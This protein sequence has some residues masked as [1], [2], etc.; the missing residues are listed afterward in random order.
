MPRLRLKTSLLNSVCI[1]GIVG[2]DGILVTAQNPEINPTDEEAALILGSSQGYAFE[3]I[4]EDKPA[5]KRKNKS[6]TPNA[7]EIE[8]GSS[9]DLSGET[10]P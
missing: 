4:E 5:I 2:F 9:A 6:D 8:L 1:A 3:V 7:E 10:K